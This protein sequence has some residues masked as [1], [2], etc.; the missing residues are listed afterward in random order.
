MRYLLFLIILTS[1]NFAV[2]MQRIGMQGLQSI[3]PRAMAVGGG[4]YLLESMRQHATASRGGGLFKPSGMLLEMNRNQAL[5]VFGMQ[6]GFDDKSLHTQY[7]QLAKKWHPDLNR[8]NPKQAEIKF[9][10]LQEAYGVLQQKVDSSSRTNSY[11]QRSATQQ[12]HA[13]QS[14]D[15]FSTYQEQKSMFKARGYSIIY[16]GTNGFCRVYTIIDDKNKKEYTVHSKD[17]GVFTRSYEVY[18]EKGVCVKSFTLP[19]ASFVLILLL[20]ELERYMK[21]H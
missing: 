1:F 15:D 16:Q 14:Q 9:K 20:N 12:R 17:T 18:D 5:K 19:K 6:D 10:E 11:Y 21:S 8:D 4:S 3:A 13:A 2:S 7:K